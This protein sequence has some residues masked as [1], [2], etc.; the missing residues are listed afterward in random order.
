M[1]HYYKN[2]SGENWFN[3]EEF[4]SYAIDVLPNNSKMVEIGSWLGRSISFFVVES[5]IKNKKIDCTCVDIWQEY[6]EIKNHP[7]FENDNA[8]NTFLQNTS[9]IKNHITPLR[10]FSIDVS[11]NFDDNSLD[12]IFIDAAHDYQNVLNDLKHWYPKLKVG[13]LIGGHDYYYTNEVAM[14]VNDFF[15]GEKINVM[16]PCWYV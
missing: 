9:L 12:F 8:Y 13:G 11:K 4:Y 1:E 7:I 10:G 2:L 6:D 16:G 5:I 14:A 15:N 3:Y